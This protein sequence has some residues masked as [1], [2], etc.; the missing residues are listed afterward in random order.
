MVKKAASVSG[1]LTNHATGEKGTVFEFPTDPHPKCK[2][3]SFLKRDD[4]LSQ[5]HM[6]P[7]AANTLPIIS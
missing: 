4:L 2:W 7:S 3:L 1:C 6:H 5:K